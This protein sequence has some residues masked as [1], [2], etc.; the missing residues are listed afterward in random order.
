[1]RKLM[2]KKNSI[3]E[4]EI[5]ESLKRSGY[6]LESEISK[7][8]NELGFFVETN[9]VIKDPLTTK[10]R[11]IDIL[12]EYYNYDPEKANNNIATKIKFVFEVKNNSFPVVLLTNFQN[13][14]NTE[15]WS[16]YKVGQTGNYSDNYDFQTN[17]HDYLLDFEK[18]KDTVFTQYCSFQRK[19]QSDELMAS[20]SEEL[21]SGL[22]KI[23]QYC[24]E[25]ASRWQN[26]DVED[27]YFRNFLYLPVVILKDDLYQL[28]IAEKNTPQLHKVDES[29]IIFNYHH[30]GFPESAIV[31]F[32]TKKGLLP[33]LQKM[34]EVE[35]KI[36][37]AM[38]QKKK[39]GT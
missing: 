34:L 24:E 25:S 1:M 5:I 14:P 35:D 7:V 13:S 3:S 9:Q 17:F 4:S 12:A 36:A 10:S 37:A 38:L 11:E 2:E 22:S 29:T 16:Y 30:N 20:H 32:V 23:T 26:Y 19:K 33:F 39:T 31:Y 6:L 15:I 27:D 28:T 18:T 8:L 21:Y